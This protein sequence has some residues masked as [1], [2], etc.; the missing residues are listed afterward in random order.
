MIKRVTRDTSVKLS[1]GEYTLM[2]CDILGMCVHD[3][4]AM[5]WVSPHSGKEELN[6]WIH[7]TTHA[8]L[9]KASEAQVERIANDIAEVLWK[10]GYRRQFKDKKLAAKPRNP[11]KSKKT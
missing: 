1:G 9:P 5:I 4:T 3:G 7:E 6:T 2:Q 11:K 8:A 10:V